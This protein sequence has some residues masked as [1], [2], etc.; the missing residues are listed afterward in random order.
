MAQ[1]FVVE[2]TENKTPNP[3][4]DKHLLFM[5]VHI[6]STFLRSLNMPLKQNQTVQKKAL[7][8]TCKEQLN[9][10]LQVHKA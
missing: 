5:M 9:Y 2:P 7:A 8:I 3:M 6:A 4:R 1:D 10:N